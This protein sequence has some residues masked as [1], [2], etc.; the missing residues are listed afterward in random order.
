MLVV[1]HVE[2]ISVATLTAA[3]RYRHVVLVAV[4][5]VEVLVIGSSLFSCL[6]EE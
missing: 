1:L 6:S 3:T 2:R 4:V 5:L